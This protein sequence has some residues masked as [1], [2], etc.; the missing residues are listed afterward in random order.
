M[1]SFAQCPTSDEALWQPQPS[2]SPAALSPTISKADPLRL[3]KS[4][5]RGKIATVLAFQ[6]VWWR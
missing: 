3:S 5:T 6:Q 2:S 4:T 1:Y